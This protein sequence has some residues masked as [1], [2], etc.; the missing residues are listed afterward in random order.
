MA[1]VREIAKEAGV[2]PATV[3]RLLTG[4]VPVNLETSNKI[5]AAIEKLDGCNT[6]SKLSNGK[7]VGIII[8]NSSTLN[9]YEHPSLFQALTSF[10]NYISRAGLS[11]STIIYDDSKE[12]IEKIFED[13]LDGYF[14][15]NTSVSQEEAISE[16]LN[17]KG[18]PHVLLNRQARKPRTGNVCLD[19]ENATTQLVEHLISLGHRKIAYVGGNKNYQNTKRRLLGYETTLKK[20]NIELD[21]SLV[22]TGEYSEQYGEMVGQQISQLKNKPTAICCGSD[23]I[24]VGCINSLKKT[25]INVPGDVAITGF[26]DYEIYRH[27]SP[28]LT[29]IIQPNSK[30]G[31]IAASCLIQLME[32]PDIDSSNTYVHTKMVIRESSGSPLLSQ[33]K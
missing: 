11:N 27:V 28:S 26:G 16:I 19:D 24:A 1:T 30:M 10:L 2:S 32:M 5:M 8:P 17:S 23:S 12:Q 15:M 22:F 31:S 18:I 29:T 33:E 14:I 6:I 9:M 13:P 25:G 21:Q 3:S 20:Y 7:R 4:K